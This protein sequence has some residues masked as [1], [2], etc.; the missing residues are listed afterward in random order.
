MLYQFFISWMIRS[1]QSNIKKSVR[2]AQLAWTHEN[3]PTPGI[4]FVQ[5][6]KQIKTK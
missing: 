3:L 2:K 4:T 5:K 6:I 1:A